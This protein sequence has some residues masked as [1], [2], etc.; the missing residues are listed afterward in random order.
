MD[1][2]PTILA[3]AG[4]PMNPEQHVDGLNILPLLNGES[5]IDRDALFWHFPHY[6][7]S[8]WTPGTAL[9]AGKWKLIE[10][11]DKE[12]IELYNLETDLEESKDLSKDYP[13]IVQDLQSRLSAVQI[14]TNARRPAPNPDFNKSI[15]K[16]K[17]PD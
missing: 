3:L 9:R 1:F 16:V 13:E 8:T 12:K 14:S 7:G 10:F 5:S 6:H 11:Y 17:V 15:D 2:Y 4:M